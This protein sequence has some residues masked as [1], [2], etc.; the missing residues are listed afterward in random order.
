[1][2]TSTHPVIGF[3]GAGNMAH[4][5]ISGL[6]AH[7]Y[8]VKHLW[9]SDTHQEK[10]DF[11]SR[12]YHG[13]HV[14][15]DNA[16]VVKEA[17]I[18][19]LAVKPQSMKNLLMD[20]SHLIK[21]QNPL[22]ISIAAGLTEKTLSHYLAY[23][24]AI[25]RCMPNVAAFVGSGVTGMY[26]NP[27]VSTLQRDLAESMMRAVGI[28]LWVKD[29]AL[30][31]TIT[32]L[33]GSGPAYFFLIIEALEKAAVELGLNE[34]DAHLLTLQTALGAARLALSTNEPA[35]E[36]RARVTSKGGITEHALAILQE[37]KVA[38]AFNA[39]LHA[40]HARAAALAKG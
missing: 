33:S 24:A 34:E 20:L 22:I 38:E 37:H 4:C 29:E 9:A 7:D 8:P 30:I 21:K 12:Q 32:V 25:V 16:T 2:T 19:V 14:S 11:I 36:L 3:I 6:I 10:L 27:H 17:Q 1:M 26:A 18:L 28:T 39:A 31:D 40:G 35:A 23:E 15:T 13:I 5:L